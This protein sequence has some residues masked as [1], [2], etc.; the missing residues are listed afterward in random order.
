MRASAAVFAIAGSSYVALL[1]GVVR[2]ILVMRL[3]GVVGR[4]LMQ[5]VYV[6]NR[7]TANAH[8]GIL[9]GL[10][11]QL[12]LSIGANDEEQAELVESVGMT[13]VVAL[14]AIAALGMCLWGL[15]EPTAKRATGMAI[16]IGGGWLLAYQTHMLYRCVLRSWGNFELLAY[17]TLIDALAAFALAVYGGYRW[18]FIGA[19]LGT[20]AAWLIDLLVIHFRSDIRIRV[21]WQTSVAFQLLKTGL[22][23]L[24]ITFS[25]TLLRT[26]D[27]A[28]IIRY[29]DAYRFGLY[30]VGMQMAAYMFTLPE[31]AGFVIWPKIIEA[32]GAS[33]DTEK[34]R[35]H[36]EVPTTAAAWVMPL[37]AGSA[38]ILLPVLIVL[39]VPEFAASTQPA[40]ILTWGG[41]FLALPLATNSLLVASGQELTVT[42]IRACSGLTLGGATY[43]LVQRQA[44]IVDIAYTAA[45]AYA[46]AS[47]LSLVV[48]LPKYHRGWRLAGELA[49]CY[50]P[51]VWAIASL[52][53]AAYL[54][55]GLMIPSEADVLWAMACLGFFVCLYGPGMIYANYH[56]DLWNEAKLLV[57]D[58]K[59]AAGAP[60]NLPSESEDRE[61]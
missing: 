45:A 10:S 49:A 29:Y 15:S 59:K 57:R 39:L 40:R 28:V 17:V 13:W 46:V 31:A 21:Q 34:L 52:R 23:I 54:A 1:L 32:W 18:G 55:G 58:Y 20:L 47:L 35:R 61:E 5:S 9:H 42:V 19:M 25:D 53:M 41:I 11:K 8:L 50:L 4:G 51:T 36:I 12:P 26:I 30:S 37:L 38:H 33:G 16:V 2:G 22:L 6:I 60:P 14:T 24:L 3:V 7:Y 44:P 48:V 56:R 27:G 43:W